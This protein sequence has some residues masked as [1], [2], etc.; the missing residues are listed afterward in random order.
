MQ[1]TRR[2]PITVEGSKDFPAG[3]KGIR[4][5]AARALRLESMRRHSV[6]CLFLVA[7]GC[8]LVPE[9]VSAQANRNLDSVP[10]HRALDD[11]KVALDE[12]WSYRHANGADFDDVMRRLRKKIDAGISTNEF[13]IE[14]QKIIA[15]GIDGHAR[16]SGYTLPGAGHLPFLVEPEGERFVAFNPER[17]AFLADGFPYLTTIDGR[18]VDDWL[19]A[20]ATL[21]PKG[22]P[23][24]VRRHCLAHLRN[25]DFLR[26]VLGLPRKDSVEV[27]L[28]DRRGEA[29]RTLV[30]RVAGSPP[31]FGTWPQGGSRVLDGNIGYLRLADMVRTTSVPE[32]TT[33]MPRFRETIGLVVDVRDNSGGE[34]DALR[35]LYSYLSGPGDPPRVVNAAAYRLHE[36]HREDHLAENHF[37]YRA[38]ARSWTNEERRAIADFVRAF[39]PQWEL[40]KG[41]FS[42][43]HYMILRRLDDPGIYFYDKPTIVLMNAKCFSATDVFLAGLKGVR[44]VT[45][46][47]TP[48][49]GGSA[50]GQEVALGATPFR[51]RIGSMASFQAD[52]M[53]FD[54]NG[55]PPD[56]VVEPTPEYY[57]GGLDTVL[58]EATRRITTKD[59]AGIRTPR[60]LHGALHAGR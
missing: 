13:G 11:L 50:F 30:L 51:V 21:V 45:L 18:E 5:V 3:R 38:D 19:A 53:L 49:A 14:L 59:G 40:P 4:D 27:A 7:V 9:W 23:Q 42:D 48:S 52:G 46:L 56:V 41:Q 47:G 44:N 26:G 58:S 37:M 20:A 25:L 36:V 31:S 24:Y 1:L 29:R 2:P 34:R 12:R 39:K 22:S 57:I 28:A 60:L 43:W 55:V 10:L 35:L 15:L 6:A 54:G 17:T 16:V 32:I 8:H 33:W